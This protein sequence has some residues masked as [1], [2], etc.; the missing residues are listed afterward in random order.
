MSNTVIKTKQSQMV[1][2]IELI[3]DIIS[4]ISPIDEE[5]NFY[6]FILEN[7]IKLME[8]ERGNKTVDSFKHIEPL[9]INFELLSE[10]KHL[11]ETKS[12]FEN[13]FYIKDFWAYGMST[14]IAK[15]MNSTR[16]NIDRYVSLGKIKESRTMDKAVF[17]LLGE[18]YGKFC[19]FS[20]FTFV[21]RF[22]FPDIKNSQM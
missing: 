1:R 19:D 16:Q 18:K 11:L 15:I 12:D 13:E 7:R 17:E 22:L 5:I 3:A 10:T 8:L 4:P 2:F 20:Y 9:N 14:Y 21:R 6:H